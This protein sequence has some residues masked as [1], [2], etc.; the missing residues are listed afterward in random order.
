MQ[1]SAMTSTY[2]TAVVTFWAPALAADAVGA[3]EEVRGTQDMR[4]K[5]TDWARS[6]MFC[7]TNE[8]NR[9]STI[10]LGD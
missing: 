3:P 10:R 4:S 5:L 2:D 6:G 9:V 7:I 1:L 8:C